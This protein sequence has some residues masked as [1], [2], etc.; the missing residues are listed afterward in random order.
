[1]KLPADLLA[2]LRGGLVAAAVALPQATAFGATVFAA[3]LGTAA[4][5][6]TGLVGA[7]LLLLIS[8]SV[9]GTFGLISSPTGA[10]MVLL[11]GTATVMAAANL[12]P[13]AIAPALFAVTV[14][15]G[16][17]QLLIALGGGGRLMKF[18]PY[19]VIAGLTTGTGLL[20]MKSQ[21]KLLFGI[22]HDQVWINWHWL[23]ALT[24]LTAFGI[25]RY[26]PRLFPRLPGSIAGLIGG[27]ALF[28]IICYHPNFPAAPAHWVIGALP[29]PD[30]FRFAA[31]WFS[32]WQTLPWPLVLNAAFALA[33]LSSL[34]TLLTSVLADTATGLRHHT[35]RELLVQSIG[36]IAVGLI[37]GMA[38]S[39]SMGGTAT[40]VRA[41]ARRWAA[42][43]A[44]VVL[45]SVL[46][47]FG[48]VGQWLPTSALAGIIIASALG[49]LET[50]I[51]AWIRRR[52]TRMDAAVTLLVAGVTLSYD[53]MI[54]VLVGL[55]IA[56]LLFIREQNRVP[57]IHRR[58]TVTE[59]PS[60]RQRPT[61]QAELLARHGDRIV[62]YELR[63]TL[64]FAKADQ[65]FEEMLPDLE[66][67]AWI[68]LHLRR[69]L[70]ID[71]SSVRLLQQIAARLEA[72]GGELLFC[73]VREDHGLG[74]EVEHALRRISL[75]PRRMNVKTFA[76]TDLALEYAENAL[77]HALGYAPTVL[78]QRVALEALDLCRDMTPVE[79]AALAVVLSRCELD[80]GER[81]FAAGDPGAALYLVLRGRVDIRLPATADRYKR[82][83]IY[84][85]GTVFGD[86]AF[87]DPGPRAAEA[88]AVKPSELLVLNRS[89]FNRLR[90]LHPD[91]AIALL[92]ALGRQ[93]SRA[94]RWSAKEIQ[95]LIQW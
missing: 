95:R 7:I 49:L 37:G 6:L 38:G 67:P 54:A 25:T 31:H 73:E 86:I 55:A 57:I 75:N 88:V 22:G 76:S 64:F 79:I 15:A 91:A 10:S 50:D 51:V 61:E 90:D 94:L 33:V 4:G 56:I 62:V 13:A 68:I 41:G 60:V 47:L 39:A 23:P 53:L 2:D 52:R 80:R 65:L 43:T 24:A 12:A 8:G 66:R 46:L 77:L 9:G 70:Q 16:L 26:V 58:L 89:D 71:F 93:Q 42:L 34:N 85:P 59:R 63:G 48:Q 82:L 29:G 87:L 69:V 3:S 78:H 74:R 72:H 17:M 92:L 83:A 84:G 35:R 5:A 21:F 20:M 40:A 27:T 14:L 81:L 45:L 32:A 36:Q 30:Q 44:G 11:S 1:M 28:Q 19:P 18:I